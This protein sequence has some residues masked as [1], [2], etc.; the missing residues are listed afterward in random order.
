M[1]L[2]SKSGIALTCLIGASGVLLGAL[3]N[4]K[5]I[6]N[7]AAKDF[8]YATA[9]WVFLGTLSLVLIYSKASR[10]AVLHELFVAISICVGLTT[11]LMGAAAPLFWR[12]SIV[13]PS[14]SVLAGLAIVALLV[15]L[16]R[17]HEYFQRAWEESNAHGVEP[18]LGSV[19][20]TVD[21]VRMARRLNLG[22]TPILPF[23]SELANQLVSVLLV[24]AMIVG[25][26]LRKPFPELSVWAWGIPALVFATALVRMA[27]VRT[28]LAGK[29]LRLEDALGQP[30]LVS[31]Q[32]PS[33]ED[34]LRGRKRRRNR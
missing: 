19:A 22:E 9:T 28:L 15:Q 2:V 1:T 17:G 13:E 5:I 12:Y 31:H 21:M 3:L 14:G 23:H 30:I 16:R 18:L 24:A 33:A 4:Y 10:R 29:L 8:A 32:V 27:F 11:L 6:G 20:R 34:R 25:L 7:V 26:N